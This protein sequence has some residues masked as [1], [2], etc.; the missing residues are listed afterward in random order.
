MLKPC[1]SATS[2]ISS[3]KRL[4]FR[5]SE[6]QSIPIF[7]L[8][9]FRHCD[10]KCTFW[11]QVYPVQYFAGISTLETKLKQAS[12]SLITYRF[13]HERIFHIPLSTTA[14]AES[15]FIWITILNSMLK[16][17]WMAVVIIFAM[18]A[19]I[20]LALSQLKNEWPAGRYII[21]QRLHCAI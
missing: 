3:R 2:C 5:K 1:I 8:A 9:H 11:R 21:Y 12:C 6:F 13:S 10:E 7:L 15:S 14:N 16:S 17:K 4:L 19:T 20:I 18:L